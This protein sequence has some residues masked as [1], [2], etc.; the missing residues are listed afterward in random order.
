MC[1]YKAHTATMFDMY[2]R[3]QFSYTVHLVTVTDRSP[4]S[5][6]RFHSNIKALLEKWSQSTVEIIFWRVT[7]G[8]GREGFHLLFLPM[9][10]KPYMDH[11]I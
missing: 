11:Y 9:V 1:I 6:C 7:N 4:Y 10:S 2:C 8:R 5:E 3:S